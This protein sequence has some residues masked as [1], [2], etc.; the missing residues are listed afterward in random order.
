MAPG[1]RP[2]TRLPL[3]PLPSS[4]GPNDCKFPAEADRDA[5]SPQSCLASWAGQCYPPDAWKTAP[6]TVTKLSVLIPVLNEADNLPALHEHLTA[7]LEKLGHDWEVVL[8]NDGSTDGSTEVLDRI[9]AADQR[10]KVV[11]LRRNFG[12]TAALMAALDHSS[13]DIIIM[14]D[15]ICRTTPATSSICWPSWGRAMTSSPAGGA[16]RRD[17]EW[18]RGWPSRRGQPLHFL[19]DRRPSP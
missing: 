10:F 4:G 18:G 7:A 12:Q 16:E 6:P 14:M 9:A 3:P 17:T 13:G 1:Q 8:A 15:A 2:V 19:D 11:H 5:R